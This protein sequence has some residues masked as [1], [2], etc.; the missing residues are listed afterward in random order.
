M[1]RSPSGGWLPIQGR[2]RSHAASNRLLLA[3]LTCPVISLQWRHGL[4]F[5][6][7]HVGVGEGVRMRRRP[8]K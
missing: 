5:M 8:D 1:P 3:D 6:L 7:K 2:R 4:N